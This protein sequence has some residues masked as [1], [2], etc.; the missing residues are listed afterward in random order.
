MLVFS[1][2]Y[3]L[4]IYQTTKNQNYDLQITIKKCRGSGISR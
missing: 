4:T 1:V 2:L 3:L